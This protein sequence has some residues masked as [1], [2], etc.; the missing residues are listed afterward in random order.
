MEITFSEGHLSKA[1]VIRVLPGSDIIE[2]IEEVCHSL[3]IKTGAITSCIGSLQ[4][5]SLMI[6]VP[7]DNKIG[8]GYSDPMALEG[9]LELL[10]G[11]GTIGQEEGGEIVIHLHGVVSD[12]EGHV[13][14]G[15][16]VKG[17][18]PVLITSEIMVTQIKGI[19]IVRG[20]DPEVDMNIFFSK[21]GVSK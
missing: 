21:K 1:V 7:L 14:G 17:K 15:H 6:A 19:R 5:A 11:Q 8:A 2:G 16:L 10:S 13:H 12:K 9:P 20:Y 18:N 3:G 4:K